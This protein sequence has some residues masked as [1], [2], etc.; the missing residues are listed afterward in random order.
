MV[1]NDIFVGGYELTDELLQIY[2]EMIQ[3]IDQNNIRTP[4]DGLLATQFLSKGKS[5]KGDLMIV[6]RAVNG[7]SSS[8]LHETYRKENP[9][10]FLEHA[11]TNS[12]DNPMQWIHAT[13]GSARGRST[14]ANKV[15]DPARSPF[16][17]LA[18]STIGKF[19]TV[20]DS[21]ETDWA[22]RLAWSNLYKVAPKNGGNPGTRLAMLQQSY[23]KRIL[24]KELEDSM[25]KRV[26]FVTATK[27]TNR[28]RDTWFHPF[29]ETVKKACDRLNIK[30]CVCHRP[31]TTPR[32]VILRDIEQDLQ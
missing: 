23:C 27:G 21:F 31:E 9:H 1:Y 30:L 22:H 24:V 5:Y 26:L 29:E 10:E 2:G 25:P 32:N 16:W 6:G 7:G 14:R 18:K 11:Y 17:Q 12:L 20:D 13:W 4:K 3:H 28:T 8:W 15:Y 19:T